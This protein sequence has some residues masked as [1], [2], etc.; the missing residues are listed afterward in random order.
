MWRPS[1]VLPQHKGRAI[2]LWVLLILSILAYSSY[3]VEQASEKIANP[4][5]SFELSNDL[6]KY[7]DI[8]VCLYNFYG[9]DTMGLEPD[10][11]YSY[12]QTEGGRANATFNPGGD[13][14]QDIATNALLTESKGWCVEFKSSDIETHSGERD[15]EDYI[16]LNM[17]WYPGG[18]PG[19]S[20]TCIAEG[21]DWESHSESVFVFLR[22]ADSGDLSAGIQMAYNCVNNASN[23]HVFN[24]V[25]IGLTKVNKLS[26]E[27]IATY[28]ALATSSALYKDKRDDKIKSTV[29]PYAYLAM[30]IAQQTDSLV[31]VTEINPF[32]V[33]EIFGQ[34]GGFW[35]LLM[36]FWPLFFVS[37]YAAEP[38]LKIR[39][40]KKSLLKGANRTMNFRRHPKPSADDMPRRTEDEERPAWD[41]GTLEDTVHR[42][43]K[44]KEQ[45][46]SQA[47]QVKPSI[48]GISNVLTPVSLT[49]FSAG[50]K[51]QHPRLSVNP[52]MCI[53]E[54]GSQRRSRNPTR[55]QGSQVAPSTVRTQRVTPPVTVSHPLG[56][57]SSPAPKR[58]LPRAPRVSREF[59]PSSG[60]VSLS[61]DANST[62]RRSASRTTQNIVPVALPLSTS[63][64]SAASSVHIPPAL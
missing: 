33:A 18:S 42:R 16:L 6:Y 1:E 5:T 64:R 49:A 4:S 41:F 7:P 14:E 40:F 29:N 52:E 30:E 27:Q 35:D 51:F 46:Y 25:G 2:L 36:I 59:S 63:P 43:G 20:T 38:H 11:M 17:D 60:S 53:S 48:K 45:Y 54:E 3:L 32:A 8:Y 37:S 9:C 31:T 44:K 47:A 12:N 58:Y 62:S 23:S 26:G 50:P 61:N 24:F 28:S 15:P 10:C 22:D 19:N 34:V 13:T 56:P 55:F 39:N 21:D 57:A